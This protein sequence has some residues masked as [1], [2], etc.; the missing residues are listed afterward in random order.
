MHCRS[1]AEAHGIPVETLSRE[2]LVFHDQSHAAYERVGKMPWL[3][4]I[5]P[6]PPVPED[7][8][9]VLRREWE[10]DVVRTKLAEESR[11]KYGIP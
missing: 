7:P 8:Q 3:P 4:L 6:S 5:L 9:E 1:S 11:E 10:L 2:W